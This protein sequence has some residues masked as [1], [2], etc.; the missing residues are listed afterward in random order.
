VRTVAK[1]SWLVIR[2]ELVRGAGDEFEPP[3]GRDFLTSSAFSLFELAV[4][5]D[6]AFGRWDRG[7]LHLFRFPDGAEYVLGGAEEGDDATDTQSMYIG[8][9]RLKPGATFEYVFDLGDEW[10]H[11][12]QILAVDVDPDVEFGD[13]PIG[14]VPLFGWGNIPD[15]Y[16]RTT[17]D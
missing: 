15:Q 11:R 16:G 13:E 3:P 8:E 7:H 1:P 12:C 5:I 6:T 2:A 4:G 9:L 17:P 14:P 10:V